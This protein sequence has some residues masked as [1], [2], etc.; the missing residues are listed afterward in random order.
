MTTQNEENVFP[1]Q[2]EPEGEAPVIRGILGRDEDDAPEPE[3]ED[4]TPADAK[5]TYSPEQIQ[6]LEEDAAT[7]KALLDNEG[8]VAAIRAASSNKPAPAIKPAAQSKARQQS[9]ENGEDL[10]ALKDEVLTEIRRLHG[11]NQALALQ[12]KHPEMQREENQIAVT[13]IAQKYGLGLVDAFDLW[14]ETRASRT[15]P[16]SR[17]KLRG[18]EGGQWGETHQED[19]LERARKAVKKS[20]GTDDAID[21]IFAQFKSN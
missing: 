8:I 20:R 7:L 18:T 11:A 1:G 17:P 12:L 14:Q 2:P 19:K 3:L 21:A 10:A 4:E 16:E 9:G 6:K 5:P 13:K 15:E